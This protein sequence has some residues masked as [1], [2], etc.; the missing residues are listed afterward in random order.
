MNFQFFHPLYYL[1]RSIIL[2]ALVRQ[3][4]WIS[5]DIWWEFFQTFFWPPD[6]FYSNF[7]KVPN[8]YVKFKEN[9]HMRLFI[10]MFFLSQLFFP[11]QLCCDA[12]QNSIFRCSSCLR[13]ENVTNFLFT[14]RLKFFFFFSLSSYI[15]FLLQ[16]LSSIN[17]IENERSGMRKWMETYFQFTHSHKYY[18]KI[19]WEWDR[20][21]KKKKKKKKG[22]R[23]SDDALPKKGRE[24]AT[25][26]KIKKK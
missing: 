1:Y 23:I 15:H 7:F 24:N 3:F 9:S 25:V 2:S 22:G 18:D 26:V 11:S 4:N 10:H 12:L 19:Y 14:N 17:W 5:Q 13:T 16:K 20:V 8:P 21:I 6:L